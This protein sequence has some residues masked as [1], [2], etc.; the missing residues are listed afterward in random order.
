MSEQLSLPAAAV[1]YA[2]HRSYDHEPT[3]RLIAAAII[4]ALAHQAGS[5]KHWHMDQLFA[6]AD[7]LEG[8][9]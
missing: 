7:E 2:M 8:K 9:S 6:L 4:R 3:R 5:A 1:L